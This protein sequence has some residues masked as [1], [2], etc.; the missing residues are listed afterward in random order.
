[1]D[2]AL[3]RP[4][5]FPAAYRAD[6]VD[7]PAAGPADHSFGAGSGSASFVAIRPESGTDWI[8]SFAGDPS[9][10]GLTGLYA[11]P[12]PRR[13]VVA[14]RGVVFLVDVLDP[15]ASVRV[16]VDGPALQIEPIVDERL[17]VLATPWT[18]TAIDATGPAWTTRRLAIDG[19]RI[20]EIIDH[21]L[22]GV[23]DPNDEEAREFAVDLRTGSVVGGQP[24]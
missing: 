10:G 15:P 9:F 7:A 17:L 20:D 14:E 5:R 1:M 16:L 4:Q 24:S 6:R 12:H 18:I 23:A 13:L 3:R 19:L 2:M 22:L 11:A 21:R 8:G